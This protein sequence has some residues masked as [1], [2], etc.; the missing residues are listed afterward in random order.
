M[1][2]QKLKYWMNAVAVLVVVLVLGISIYG[3]KAGIFRDMDAMLAF[4]GRAGG[5]GVGL[6]LFVQIA[7]VVVPIIP[8]GVSCMVGVLLFGP[9]QGFFLN[10]LGMVIGSLINF[11]LARVYGK[12]FLHMT[13]K[14]ATYDKYIGWIDRGKKFDILFALAIVVPFMPD[15][16][17]CMLAGI[18]KM[19]LR[20]FLLI[21][22]LGRPFSLFA[23]SGAMLGGAS[24]LR[25]IW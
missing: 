18:S 8:G 7:Q 21:I 20:K 15:D 22:L 25:K 2:Q 12:P 9:W 16:F 11:F 19:S 1:P 10:Y 13:V 4:V 6:F 23:Y 5:W 3:I 24:W 17:L 14:D